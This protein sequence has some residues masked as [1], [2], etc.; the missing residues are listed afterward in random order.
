M[1]IW[2]LRQV[3]GFIL[4][5][6]VNEVTVN[7]KNYQGCQFDVDFIQC[8]TSTDISRSVNEFFYAQNYFQ[9]VYIP[10]QPIIGDKT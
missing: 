10:I 9:Y 3:K 6:L 2:C 1:F 4:K 5:F 8:Q 7:Q